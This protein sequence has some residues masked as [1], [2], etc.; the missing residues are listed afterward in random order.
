MHS[1][2]KAA[3]FN[4]LL[5]RVPKPFRSCCS[6]LRNYYSHSGATLCFQGHFILFYSRLS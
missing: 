2:G 5:V 4:L 3:L 1:L 6:Q